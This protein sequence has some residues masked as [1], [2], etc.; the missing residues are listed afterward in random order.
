MKRKDTLG[1][2]IKTLDNLFF[3]N[4]IAYETCQEGMDEVTVMHG[5]ILGFLYE[6]QERLIFQKDIEA[7]FSIARS[8][9]TAIV[10]LMEKKGYK[11]YYVNLA[12]QDLDLVNSPNKLHI[13]NG[14]GAS[15]NRDKAKEVLSE[16]IDEV[17]ETLDN[18]ITEKYVFT[19]FSL[20]GGTGSGCGPFLSSVIAENPEKKVGL[21]II[22]PSMEESL[23]ARINA[24]E[25][26]SE[27]IPLK[28]CLGSIFI[29]DNNK[30]KD[31]LSINRSFAGLFDSFINI[32]DV[33]SSIH[34]VIDIAEQKTL[35]ETSG[36]ALI[37]KVAQN[38]QSNL[39]ATV[40]DGIYATIEPN[41]KIKYIGLSQPEAKEDKGTIEISSVID[42]VGQPIDTYMGYGNT[43]T[44]LYLGGMSFP[45]T[46]INSLADSIKEEKDKAEKVM[47]DDDIAMDNLNFLANRKSTVVV[48]K[49]PEKKMTARERLL[50]SRNNGKK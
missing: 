31:K 30:R 6:N 26:L 22:L 25:A 3:R 47:E 48:E 42:V 34:G 2:W 15:K 21:V 12:Q 13:K 4:M 41:K 18:Q 11:A 45:K 39:L 14:E 33:P 7:E 9:V 5:W 43:E 28:N 35:L 50:A 40:N 29:L 36:V 19:V 17:L 37:H 8:T 38:E 44:V 46:Y 20:G 1:F 32:G 10:K 16:S 49:E 24:Y 27:I 23:Q